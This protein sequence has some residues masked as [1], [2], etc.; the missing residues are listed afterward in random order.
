VRDEGYGRDGSRS[1]PAIDSAGGAPAALTVTVRLFAGL[2]E[3][4]RWGERRVT[5]PHD[6]ADPP[7]PQVLWGH[8]ALG[9]PSLPPKL[10]VAVNHA[11]AAPDT[12]LQDGDEVAFLPPISGG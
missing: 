8:L 11:F 7:T 12:P 10:R 6:P 4:A 3:Q 2:R 1:G 9:G 5:I